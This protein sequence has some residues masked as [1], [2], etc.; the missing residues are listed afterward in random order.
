M[1]A[2]VISTVAYGVSF[3]MPSEANSDTTQLTKVFPAEMSLPAEAW[4]I[5]LTFGFGSTTDFVADRNLD[6]GADLDENLWT[7]GNI[8]YD[9]DPRVHLS[10]FL[11]SAWL[12]VGSVPID[13]DTTTKVTLDADAAFAVGT[14]VKVD[15]T[16]FEVIPDQPKMNL[17]V[18]GGYRHTNSDVRE[19]D[20]GGF[21]DRSQSLELEINEW[22]GTVGVSQ[23]INDPLKLWFG[24]TWCNFAWVPYLAVQ[25]SDLDLNVSGQSQLPNSNSIISQSVQTGH[26]NSDGVVNLVVGMQVIG[27]GDKLS[28]DLEGRML[29]ES[30][31]TLGAHFR[32]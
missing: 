4:G 12:R 7:G 10:L 17:F 25:Y 22:Q 1:A 16:D 23:R 27:F 14:G 28:I 11:G 9:P 2:F 26:V 15:V 6:N 3:A 29:A 5:P 21:N 32:W 24:W 8:Y 18:S 13:T 20:G 31:L 30:A 19:V